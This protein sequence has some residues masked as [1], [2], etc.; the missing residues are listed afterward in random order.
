M[1][2]ELT[3]VLVVFS[4]H[5]CPQ[6]SI[7]AFD[8]VS[9][10][11]LEHAVSVCAVNQLGVALTTLVRHAC[12]IWVALFTV[13]TDNGG[14]VVLIREQKVL[15]ILVTVNQHLTHGV[16]H[17]RIDAAFIH[18]VLEELREN[19]QAVTLLDF[20]HKGR[21]WQQRTHRQDERLDEVIRALEI[22]QCAD[23]LGRL[24]RIDLLHVSLN[25]T[26]HV[27]VVQ[28]RREVGHK[29][30]TIANVDERSGIRELGFH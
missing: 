8:D 12:Q 5:G 28:V 29:V 1:V 6:L 10:L 21:D 24:L 22:Q 19:L 7:H 3:T 11:N 26:Q 17:L 23:N 20:F 13:A 2:D 30:E 9:R 4:Q 14:F 25:V 15:G 18:E 16:V 27:V